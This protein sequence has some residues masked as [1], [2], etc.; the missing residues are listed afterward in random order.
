MRFCNVLTFDK[1]TE[2]VSL[3]ISNLFKMRNINSKDITHLGKI[4]RCSLL[5]KNGLLSSF[6][7]KKDTGI[8]CWTNSDLYIGKYKL[9]DFRLGCVTLSPF[10]LL[11]SSVFFRVPLKAYIIIG[12]LFYFF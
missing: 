7:F 9:D 4:I 6:I 1:K 10:V 11:V 8:S 2:K 12:G 3:D 5:K